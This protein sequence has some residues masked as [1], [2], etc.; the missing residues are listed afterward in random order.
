LKKSQEVKTPPGPVTKIGNYLGLSTEF[1]GE[2]ST[3]FFRRDNSGGGGLVTVTG[4]TCGDRGNKV[5]PCLN[6]NSAIRI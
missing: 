6:G 5:E 2:F 3:E 4:G 1:H